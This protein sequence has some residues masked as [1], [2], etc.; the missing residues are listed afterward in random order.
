MGPSPFNPASYC[1]IAF[2]SFS[3]TTEAGAVKFNRTK[4]IPGSEKYF[5]TANGTDINV[6][7]TGPYEITLCG[8]ISGVTDATGASFELYNSTTK[9]TVSDLDLK[10]EKGNTP[11]MDFSETDVVDIYAPATLQVVTNITGNDT[12]KFCH[13]NILIKG[14]S[15]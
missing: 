9:A 6:N 14:Y 10:L 15:A 3:D 12:I 1:A 2:V 11:D 4:L 7:T 5:T 8:R 13:I